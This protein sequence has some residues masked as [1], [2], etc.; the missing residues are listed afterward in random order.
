MKPQA[1]PLLPLPAAL[2]ELSPALRGDI[3]LLNDLLGE[4]LTAQEGP[5]LAGLAQALVAEEDLDPR[6]LERR[7]PALADPQVVQRL[8]RAFTVFFQVLNVAEQKEIIRVNRERSARGEPR[9]ESIG[10][11]VARLRAAGLPPA[12]LQAL[13]DRLY[14]CPTLTAH[15]TEARRR[16]VMDKL[17]AIAGWLAE[18]SGP[19]VSPRLDRPLDTAGLAERELRRALTALWQTD[20]LRATALTVDDEVRNGL[21]FFENTIL[22]VVPW[23]HADLRAALDREYPGHE[24]RI[25]PFI[26]YRSWVGGDRDG[27]PNVTPEVTWQ[28]LLRH[29]ELVLRHYLGRVERLRRELTQSLRLVPAAEALLASLAADAALVPLPERR[30]V[31]FEREPYALKLLYVHQRLAATLEHLD[32]IQDF[33][34]E[35]P[36][37]AAQPPAYETSPQFLADLLLIQESLR[38]H[39]AAVLAETGA[40]PELITAV[41]TFGF[42]LASLDV[43]QHS[44]EHQRAVAELLA[45]ARALPPEVDY[46]ALSEADKVRLLTRELS[47]PRSLLARRF[48]PSAATAPVLRVFEVIGHAQRYISPHSVTTYIISMTHGVSDLLE[49]LLLAKEYGLARWT[50][51]PDSPEGGLES[52]LD[53]VPLFETIDDLH[54]C[55][56]LMRGLFRNRVYRRQLAAREGFQEVMLGYSDSSKDGGY[57][58]ANWALH[59]TQARLFRLCAAEGVRLRL[60]HGRGG[61]VGRGGGRANQAILSQPPGFDGAIRFTEQ[62]EVVSFRYSL[63]PIA[64]RHLE[65]I[66]GAVLLAAGSAAAGVGPR[67]EPQ[68]WGGVLRALAA[69]SRDV[70]RELVYED[71]DF[72]SFYT[73]AT[74]IQHISRLTIASRPVF[75]PGRAGGAQHLRAVPWVF[76]WVQ[77]RYGVPGWYGMGSA[78]EWFVAQEPGNAALLQRLYRRWPFFRTVLHNA[79]LELLRAHLPTAA[80]YAA[81][82]QPPELGER[83]HRQLAEEYERTRK[84]VMWIVGEETLLTRA[85]VIRRTIALRNPATLPLS[86]LQ[87]ALLDRLAQAPDDPDPAWR[88]AVLLSITGVAAAMQST[89]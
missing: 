56:E 23:L 4:V 57:L 48:T 63:A 33:L 34:H 25:P 84:W 75:R 9:S 78:L 88:E 81:R 19:A 52:D 58:A 42:R 54:D 20:E 41:R 69:H 36:S 24:F 27:N 28:T 67:R 68:A 85:P 77:S 5:E 32:R 1:S 44:D 43:R 80:W 18:R 11:A 40:L 53:I 70:Y 12:E 45:A 10:E 86:K 76:A 30:R 35:G 87:V 66:A 26:R 50:G 31:R 6:E 65:Q 16:A 61:T 72:W 71:P 7:F 39:G 46:A 82:V 89:G 22:E 14:I 59:D 83:M 38:A 73:Q 64:H 8:L 15:P 51:D 47:T 3:E 49:V 55:H 29:K 17:Q 79:Q 74:P 13:L 62:G 37:F 21:Y 2:L 60:F